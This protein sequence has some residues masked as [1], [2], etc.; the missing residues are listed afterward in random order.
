M[1]L[2][3]LTDDLVL[4]V[5]GVG[6]LQLSG[7]RDGRPPAEAEQQQIQLVEDDVVG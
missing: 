7:L 5:D 1:K 2:L 4:A 3:R 6:G